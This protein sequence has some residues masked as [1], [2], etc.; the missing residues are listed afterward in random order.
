MKKYSTILQFVIFCFSL[1]ISSQSNWYVATN[2]SDASGDGS[3]NNPFASLQKAEQMVG[4]GDTV[5]VFGGTY[6]NSDFNDG[7][8]WNGDNLLRITADGTENNYITFKPFPGDEVILE[9]D[10]TYGILISNSS[11]IQ[12]EGFIVKGISDNISQSE[13]D[14]A[15]GLY[16]DENGVIKDLAIELGI[17]INDPNI[18]GTEINKP[19][20]P[21]ISK[22]TYYNGR[23]IVANGSHHITILKN[24][25]KHVPSSAIRVQQSDYVTVSENTVHQNTYWTTQGVGAITVAEAMPLPVGDTSNDIKIKLERNNVYNNENRLISW[26]PNKTFVKMVIDEGTGL[27]LTRNRDTYTNGY[28]LIAN[29]ISAFSGAS[30]IVSHFTNRVIIEHNTVYKNGT[31]NDSPA[32]GIGINNTDDVTIRNNISYAEPDHWAIGIL[33]QP[34]TNTLVENNLIYNENGSEP[35]HRNLP[36]GWVEDNPLF[37]DS[38]NSDFNLTTN[39]PAIDNGATSSL[40]TEDF[41]GNPRNDGSP[42]IGAF[43]FDASLSVEIFAENLDVTMYPNPFSEY[44]ILNISRLENDQGLINIYDNLGRMVHHQVAKPGVNNIAFNGNSGVYVLNIQYAERQ[45]TYRIIKN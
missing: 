4:A 36:S 35:I 16:K 32:G 13:A 21:N 41:N 42:D 18:A 14:S 5:F 40:Q 23:G 28:I 29:N 39:S 31:T 15:W 11:Y 43:E 44:L 33:A 25:V 8:I 9:F 12:I 7:D 17:D 27:F 30:G 3:I 6:R 19:S 22:P 2:G 34:N 37:I 26:N 38:S 45:M 1:T 24:E 20:M 10:S